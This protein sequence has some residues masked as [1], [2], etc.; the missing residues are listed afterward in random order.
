VWESESGVAFLYYA[1]VVLFYLFVHSPCWCYQQQESIDN[2]IR[3]SVLV[4]VITN[5]MPNKFHP[6]RGL[7]FAQP[8]LFFLLLLNPLRG[9]G[10]VHWNLFFD[11]L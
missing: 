5:K 9:L 4:V 6:L 8:L 1:L 7:Q 3:C 10:C 11:G 2:Q